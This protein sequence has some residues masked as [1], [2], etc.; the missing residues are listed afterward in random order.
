MDF[1]L[2]YK[3]ASMNSALKNTP[4]I[5]ICTALLFSVV[6]PASAKIIARDYE[7]RSDGKTFQGYIA[8]DDRFTGK[9][10]G[11]LVAHQWKGL[12]AYEKERA[13]QLAQ[14]GYV[15]FCVDVYGKGI[16]PTAAKDAG[17]QAGKYKGDR[18]LLKRRAVAG[19]TVLKNFRLTNPNKTAAIGYCFGGATVLELA[20]SGANVGGVISYHGTL[21][22]PRP[23]EARNIKGKVLVLHGASDPLSDWK[24]I[25]AINDEMTKAKVDFEINLYGHA[26]HSFTEKKAGNNPASGVAYNEKADRRSWEKTK[27]FFNEIFR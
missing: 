9:R 11:V 1:S 14:M 12:G 20:R 15:A 17:A 23:A 26:V 8:Y 25:A 2:R 24:E 6:A 13:R 21:D 3:L 19:F 10:P 7:Y 22:T 16:R 4:A 27:A 5:A 18:A